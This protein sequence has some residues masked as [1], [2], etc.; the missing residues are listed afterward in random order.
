MEGRVLMYIDYNHK[1]NT[2]TV[3]GPLAALPVIF[4]EKLPSSVL[5]VGCGV[6]TWLA[7][8]GKLGVGDLYGIDGI[9][10]DEQNLLI[11]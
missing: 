4:H 8:F 5:D 2:H 10:L 1:E 3:R 9:D 7:A 6:G 11:D